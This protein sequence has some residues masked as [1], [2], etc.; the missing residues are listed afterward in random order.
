MWRFKF[1]WLLSTFSIRNNPVCMWREAAGNGF[2]NSAKSE[3]KG[4]PCLSCKGLQSLLSHSSPSMVPPSLLPRHRANFVSSVLTQ[5]PCFNH[6]LSCTL[7][8]QPLSVCSWPSLLL[9]IPSLILSTYTNPA[10]FLW[11]IQVSLPIRSP[12]RSPSIGFAC[13]GTT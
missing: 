11:F 8:F 3:G 9:G 10:I 5:P 1:L 6:S 13:W 7:S 12:Q 2:G 4:L